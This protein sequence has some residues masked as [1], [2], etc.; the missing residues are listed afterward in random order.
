MATGERSLL[1][2]ARDDAGVLMQAT[3]EEERQGV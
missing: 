3:S 2:F 1:F